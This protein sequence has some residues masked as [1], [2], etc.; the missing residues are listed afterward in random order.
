MREAPMCSE[1][2]LNGTRCCAIPEDILGLSPFPAGEVVEALTARGEEKC[3]EFAL[4][5]KV[6]I[7]YISVG[8]WNR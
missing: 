5:V 3:S 2:R 1:G 6:K 7:L 8:N 4:A